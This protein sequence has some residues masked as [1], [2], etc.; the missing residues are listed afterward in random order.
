MTFPKL[1][2]FCCQLTEAPH[3]VTLSQLQVEWPLKL[4]LMHDTC[5]SRRTNQEVFAVCQ[6]FSNKI[7]QYG[8]GSLPS[9]Y[10]DHCE[11]Y[12]SRAIW[13]GEGRGLLDWPASRTGP[14]EKSSNRSQLKEECWNPGLRKEG[15]QE[16]H[17]RGENGLLLY[18]FITP[19]KEID[20][21]LC[22]ISIL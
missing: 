6:K 18:S 8:L 11:H 10:L 3:A 15:L 4:H 5:D 14:G 12:R 9:P 22:I 19:S 17:P 1:K 13:L 20:I 16:H 7:Q 21:S 2:T